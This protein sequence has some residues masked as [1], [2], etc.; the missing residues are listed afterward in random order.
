MGSCHCEQLLKRALQRRWSVGTQRESV[1]EVFP[2][3]SLTLHPP[4]S[5]CSTGLVPQK[6]NFGT[7]R[8]PRKMCFFKWPLVSLHAPSKTR[9]L[10]RHLPA[11]ST[12]RVT[13][14]F[15]N[16]ER[17]GK[18][19]AD[20]YPRLGIHA[21]GAIA[22][23]KIDQ[24]PVAPRAVRATNTASATMLGFLGST[25]IPCLL[26]LDLFRSLCAG[27]L[28]P[29]SDLAEKSPFQPFLCPCQR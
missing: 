22:K 25:G 14:S 8:S 3:R 2:L 16:C 29:E 17:I 12:I 27:V 11:T 20:D 24:L 28:G 19:A 26:C 5:S 7:F 13:F 4:L 21:A 18:N 23:K 9:T 1:L 10:A 6:S 15:Q